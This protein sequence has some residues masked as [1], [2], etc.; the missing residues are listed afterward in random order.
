M[1]ARVILN[2]YSSRWNSKTRWP[3]SLDARSIPKYIDTELFPYLKVMM[4][5]DSEAW[6]LFDMDKKNKYRRETFAVF[7]RI[8]LLIG[9]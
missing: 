2:P 6:S 7:E 1:T 9:G 3:A 8:S 4:R 5:V